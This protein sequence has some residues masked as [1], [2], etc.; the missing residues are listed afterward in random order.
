MIA[1]WIAYGLALSVLLWVAA[2]SAEN[3]L[4]TQRRAARWVWA[5]ALA[6]PL[7]LPAIA[8]VRPASSVGG[9][10]EAIAA[11][12]VAVTALRSLGELGLVSGTTLT[13]TGAVLL[14]L[15]ALL[16]L[17]ATLVF[18]LGVMRA[19][20]ERRGWSEDVVGGQRVR[21]S[22]AFGPAVVGVIRPEI[23]L[24]RWMSSLDGDSLDL[25][26]RHEREHVAARDTLLLAAGFF[27]AA[28]LPWN[29]LAWLALRR[30][31]MA[32]E[33]DCD[34]RVL[35]AGSDR[36]RYGELL[37]RVG[38][39]ESRAP[40]AAAALTEPT[41]FLERR[42]R[43]MTEA[44]RIHLLRTVG[45]TLLAGVALTLACDV[46]SPTQLRTTEPIEPAAPSAAA[47]PAEPL[48]AVFVDGVRL[49]GD[50]R[51][52]IERIAPDDVE[53]IEVVKGDAARLAHPGDAEAAN[54]VIYIFTRKSVGK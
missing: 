36:R 29:P 44:K 37:I 3:A 53:R 38:E 26:L 42:I 43:V 27:A 15:W 31:R 18:V 10:G 46:P 23:V 5:G 33:I 8:A 25:V 16:S 19:R 49:S 40:L 35:R 32:I 2:S 52:Q 41:S 4:R 48:P 17:A 28:A 21:V 24:P 50:T 12:P 45:A 13:R 9:Y 1:L 7:V 30:L 47:T 34:L 11:S 39:H 51:A 20:R 54:G 6:A 22:D 14:A